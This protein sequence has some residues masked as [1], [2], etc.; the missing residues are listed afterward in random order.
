MFASKDV[1]ARLYGS[2]Q[3]RERALS[4]FSL[5]LGPTLPHLHFTLHAVA[6]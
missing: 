5:L 1:V 3:A 2:F 4:N 6:F